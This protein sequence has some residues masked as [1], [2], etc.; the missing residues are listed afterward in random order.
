VGDFTGC[1]HKV[2]GDGDGTLGDCAW[3]ATW[4]ALG[5]PLGRIAEAIRGVDTALR[6][7]EGVAAALEALKT[8]DVDA[9]TLADIEHQVEVYEEERTARRV[10]SFPGTTQVV[11]ADGSHKAREG[12]REFA[13]SLFAAHAVHQHQEGHRA[14]VGVP[15]DLAVVDQARD[16]GP[17]CIVR[18][19]VGGV[20]GAGGER[21]LPVRGV[22]G[23]GAGGV[24][25]EVR[26]RGIG[27]CCVAGIVTKSCRSR[28]CW[29]GGLPGPPCDGT[30]PAVCPHGRTLAVTTASA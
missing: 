17:G 3:A 6:S 2:T 18:G 12:G 26:G 9:E 4:L 15:C 27:S 25:D 24:R 30:G 28:L 22:E 16:R 13:G 23:G 14:C 8:L 1:Y 11:L 5:G 29:R 10:N 7:G 20:A 19:V 21:G